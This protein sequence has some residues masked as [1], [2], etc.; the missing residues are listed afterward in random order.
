MYKR[1]GEY[2]YTGIYDF[3]GEDNNDY[4]IIISTPYDINENGE[5]YYNI[6]KGWFK[7]LDNNLNVV[8]H[9]GDNSDNINSYTEEELGYITGDYPKEYYLTTVS[10]THLCLKQLMDCY[11]EYKTSVLGVQTVAPQDVN[12]YGIVGGIHI[13]DRVYK[14][15]DLVEKPSIEE[16]P[17]NVAILGRY[18]DVYKRQVIRF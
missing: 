5:S 1:Q 15:K 16:A 4:K 6:D 9:L 2:I 12:K 3:K 11:G 13:E 14:V 8:Y 17:S 10:Y 18:I 7:V